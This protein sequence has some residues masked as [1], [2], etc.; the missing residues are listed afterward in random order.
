MLL[1][2]RA[3]EK[4]GTVVVRPLSQSE[5]V[6][7]GAP[8]VQ[9]AYDFQITRQPQKAQPYERNTSEHYGYHLFHDGIYES[10]QTRHVEITNVLMI[11]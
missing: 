1:T 6:L 3:A 7:R 9:T 10:V 2:C 8:L 4:E 5:R 11:Y